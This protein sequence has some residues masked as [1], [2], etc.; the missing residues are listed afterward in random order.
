MVRT[1]SQHA[2][3]LTGRLRAARPLLLADALVVGVALA[4]A[5]VV[6]FGTRDDPARIGPL[7]TSYATVS[8]VL[9]LLWI[10]ILAA[11]NGYVS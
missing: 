2:Q 1:D 7:D 5:H 4:A 6:R 10:G 3:T 9:G 11:L 8:V